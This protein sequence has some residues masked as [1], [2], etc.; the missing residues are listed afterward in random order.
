MRIP[1][2]LAAASLLLLA[3]ACR[4]EQAGPKRRAAPASSAAAP[5]AAGATLGGGALRYKGSR[6]SA[7]RGRAGDGVQVLHQ[8]EVLKPPPPGYRL[9]V[10]LLDEASGEQLANL[11]HD[12][13]GGASSPEQWPVGQV[14]EDRHA[15]RLPAAPSGRV[16]LV[17]GFWNDAGRLA[18]DS[19]SAHLG[20]QRLLGPV[21]E[22]VRDDLPVYRA[23]RAATPP[24]VDGA[25]D[26]AAWATA[27]AVQLA[28][29][30]DGRKASLRTLARVAWD[31]QF[32]YLAFDCEDPDAWGSFA[33]RDDPIYNEEAVEAFFDANGDGRTYNELQVSPNN[34]QFDAA[35]VSYRSDLGAARAWQSSFTSA[36]KVRGTVNDGSDK[37]EGWSVEMRIPISELMEVPSTPPR[38]GDRWRFNLYRLEKVNRDQQEG[39]SFSP[40]FK[41][42]FHHLPRFGWLEFAG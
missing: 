6:V 32:I 17:L 14:V 25:L 21:F 1:R 2:L 36:V 19:A 7:L 4:D 11:D 24:V 42:D 8:F 20:D 10:H 33:Q 35:F 23:P 40:L 18:V 26:D 22:L 3:G 38:P 9:F 41:G 34:V 15:F 5:A 37:D 28:G 39:Q 29:S 16:R 13:Q 12:I 30:F 27:P 31:E